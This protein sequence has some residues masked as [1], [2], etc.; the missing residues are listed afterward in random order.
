[1]NGRHVGGS[2]LLLKAVGNAVLSK[3]FGFIRFL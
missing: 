3:D 1:M 2:G